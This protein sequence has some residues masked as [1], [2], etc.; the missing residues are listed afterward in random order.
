METAENSIPAPSPNTPE[1]MV[2]KLGIRDGVG[3]PYTCAKFR[4]DKVFCSP[5]LPRAYKVTRLVNFLGGVFLFSTAK[6]L[7]LL[8][9]INTSH[10]VV[11]R[12][13]VPF[14][15]PKTKFYISTPIPPKTVNDT[16]VKKQQFTA[17]TRRSKTA[18][19]TK[20]DM[21]LQHIAKMSLC[22]E[23]ISSVV[24]FESYKL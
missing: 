21:T 17:Q 23:V 2:T 16:N 19:I 4:S 12:K 6:T 5:P 9:M 14:G 7:A 15:A 22:C 13:D 8:F 3:E 10:D 18:N 20:A 24:I 11:S 1:P